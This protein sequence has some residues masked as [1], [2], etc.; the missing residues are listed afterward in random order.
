MGVELDF[1]ANGPV[2]GRFHTSI[3]IELWD[4]NQSAPLAQ[5]VALYLD[6]YWCMAESVNGDRT[7]ILICEFTQWVEFA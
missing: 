7:P 2:N 3:R 6:P 1:M 4:H 5:R